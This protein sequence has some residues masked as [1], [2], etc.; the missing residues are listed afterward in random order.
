MRS[1]SLLY[2]CSYVMQDSPKHRCFVLSAV[3]IPRSLSASHSTTPCTT[4]LPQVASSCLWSART[5][6]AS[7]FQFHPALWVRAELHCRFAPTM[8]VSLFVSSLLTDVG[9]SSYPYMSQGNTASA[10]T[11][12][13]GMYPSTPCD[14]PSRRRHSLCAKTDPQHMISNTACAIQSDP[15]VG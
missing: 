7:R 9:L 10:H 12:A 15:Q 6:T 4:L 3:P 11:L 13:L 1:V 5:M 8:L 14:F 2:P